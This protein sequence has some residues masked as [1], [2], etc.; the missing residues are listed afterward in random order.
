LNWYSVTPSA[1]PP[2]LVVATA[3]KRTFSPFSKT[4][5]LSELVAV[6]TTL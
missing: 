6:R 3:L 1:Q 2:G 5:S 4:P